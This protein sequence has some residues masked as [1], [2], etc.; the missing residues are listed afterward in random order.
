MWGESAAQGSSLHPGETEQ[1]DRIA[2]SRIF[3]LSVQ[4]GRSWTRLLVAIAT[5]VVVACGG[6]EPAQEAAPADANADPAPQLQRGPQAIV[7]DLPAVER[8][9]TVEGFDLPESMRHYPADDVY[10][11]SNIGSHPTR[12][13]NDGFISRLLPDGG[14]DE[15]RFI[16]GGEGGVTLN[17]PK[18][19]RVLGDTLWVTDVT[20]VRAFDA[21]TGAALFSVDL[22]DLGAVFLNALDRGGDGAMYVTDSGLRF[23]DDGSNEYIGIDR[24]FRI[25]PSGNASIAIETDLIQAPNG[26]DWD[27]GS[28]M[29]V[30]ASR[31]GTSLW[32]WPVDLADPVELVR[33][34]R[35]TMEPSRCPMVG[36]SPR[37]GVRATSRCCGAPVAYSPSSEGWSN[38]PTSGSTLAAT[39]C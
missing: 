13:D 7:G 30:V 17:A 3:E 11:V 16:A 38:R 1:V 24:I 33:D 39:A 19:M 14:I 9:L 4:V 2:E 12:L 20:V 28:Q 35:V 25:D 29:F 27:D 23:N 32:A 26:I 34:H 5:L 31:N 15:M 21:A 10:F 18:G 37:V 8:V 22:S 6:G 36:S